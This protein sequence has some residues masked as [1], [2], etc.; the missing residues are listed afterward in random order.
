MGP[1]NPANSAQSLLTPGVGLMP[2]RLV[3]IGQLLSDP[4][5]FLGTMASSIAGALGIWAFNAEAW[6]AGL[7]AVGIGLSICIV[8]LSPAIA[9]TI[10]DVGKAWIDVLAYKKQLLADQ[11][12]TLIE[13]KTVAT[14]AQA[15]TLENKSAIKGLMQ[16]QRDREQ[17]VLDLQR[18]LAEAKRTIAENAEASE[19][20]RADTE[21]RTDISTGELLKMRVA[22]RENAA[23]IDQIER[24]SND[25]DREVRQ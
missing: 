11:V 1:T 22:T 21:H 10:R 20:R 6:S 4:T 9:Q 2:Q 13:T 12:P 14:E 18:E 24:R 7:G 16:A 25:P 19:Q 17:Q 5:W 8:R 15:A 23:R 3:L